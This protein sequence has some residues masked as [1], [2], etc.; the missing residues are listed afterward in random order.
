MSPD[1]IQQGI[2]EQVM[3]THVRLASNPVEVKQ[4]KIFKMTTQRIPSTQRKVNQVTKQVEDTME[5]KII[6]TK[7]QRRK[8]EPGKDQTVPVV[9][10]WQVPTV[11]T[12]HKNREDSTG[13][14]HRQSFRHLRDHAD[15]SA[16]GAEPRRACTRTAQ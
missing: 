3:N 4:P 13:A 2:F 12:V 15:A 14:V 9:M 6:K 1:R 8:P 7:V 16:D 5:V 10:L 11:Q